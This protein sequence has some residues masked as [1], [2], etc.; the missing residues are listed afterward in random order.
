M[1]VQVDYKAVVASP[2]VAA[3]WEDSVNLTVAGRIEAGKTRLLSE[4]S[5]L[6]KTQLQLLSPLE[7]AVFAGREH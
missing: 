1:Y 3:S 5:R 4:Q 7:D 6:G 2:L